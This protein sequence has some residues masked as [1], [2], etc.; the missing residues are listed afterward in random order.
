[1]RDLVRAS[2]FFLISSFWMA[3]AWA[4][5][6]R[7]EVASRRPVLEGR[8]FGLAGPYEILTGKMYFA[9][10]PGNPANR[11]ITDLDR[12]PQNPQG[13]VE[14]SSD[15]YL[16][17]PRDV[18]RGNGILLFEVVNRGRKLMLSFFNIAAGSLDPQAKP[19]FGDGYLMREGYTVLWVGWQFDPPRLEHLLRLYTPTASDAGRAIRGLVRSDFVVQQRLPDHSLADREHLA[20]PVAD[21]E[22][23]EN[24]MTVREGVQAP[25]TTIPRSQWKFARQ[26]GNRVVP[27][28]TRVHLEGGFEPGKIYEVVYVSE[29]PPLVGLGPAAVRDAVSRLKFSGEE[30][31]SI[32]PGALPHAL[33]FGISQSGRFLRTFLYY[34][35]NQ[36]EQQRKVFDGVIAHVAGAGRGSFNHRFAQPSRD[37][38]PYMNFL[39]PTDIFPFTDVAQTDPETGLTDGLLTHQLEEK[40]WPK[41][42]YTNSSYE[43]WG[44][45]ASLI[46][47]RID[48]RGDAPLLDNVRVYLLAGSQHGP[49]GFPPGITIGQQRA[50][51]MDFRWS[52]RA[53]LRSMAQWVTQETPPPPSRYPRLDNHT[54]VPPEELNF[55]KIPGVRFSSRVHR[56][57]RVDYGPHFRT[58][59]IVTREPPEVGTA[60]PIL[61]PAVDADG[62]ETSGIRMPELAVPLATYTGWNLFNPESGPP[63]EISS[64]VGSYIPFPRTRSEREASGDPRLSIEERYASLEEYLGRVGQ[65]GLEMVRQGYLLDEDLPEILENGRRHWEYLMA[66]P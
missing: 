5:L 62:N 52:M 4:G 51:P 49:A 48:G 57:Y 9:V 21:A 55:P 17:K 30:A 6:E 27:D 18:R 32:P 14:F 45:A 63:H 44:R 58:Q 33:G 50:N 8:S 43:Y 42:F 56:A 25:R 12:A 37:A 26:E 7:V 20:Y 41:I 11:I 64:M 39:Y 40:F 34:G 54:L 38:H 31:L 3:P 35:F 59:G 46:H 61:V 13:K 28:R 65:A 23:P 22:A 36:D 1:M 15:F 53:L 29:N 10:D 66:F 47:T 16:L 24:V 60:F 19:H 2:L